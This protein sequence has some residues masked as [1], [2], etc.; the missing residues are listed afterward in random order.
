[1]ATRPPPSRSTRLIGVALVASVLVAI[2]SQS[3]K[4]QKA[5]SPSEGAANE[6]PP[7]PVVPSCP[8]GTLPDQGV[9]IPVPPA[10]TLVPASTSHLGLMPGRAEDYASYLTPISAYPARAADD[11]QGMLIPAPARTVVTLISLEHQIGSARRLVLPGPEPRLLTLHKVSRHAVT[12]SYVL[13]YEG[14]S[15]DADAAEADIPVGTPLGRVSASPGAGRAA[16]RL[17]VRQL[18]RGAHPDQLRAHRLLS[19]AVSI[20]CDPRNV[21]P[22]KPALSPSLE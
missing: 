6:V 5:G 4:R 13:V 21:L 15:F 2:A 11:G 14:L 17:T 9:C 1:M 8:A 12:R 18:R 16:L 3:V 7:R 20:A 22:V 10:E 19:D